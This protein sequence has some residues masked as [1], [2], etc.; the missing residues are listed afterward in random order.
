MTTT[1]SFITLHKATSVSHEHAL[2]IGILLYK[3][4]FRLFNS[5]I[6][7]KLIIAGIIICLQELF[8]RQRNLG[9]AG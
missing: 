6:I 9:L 4:A 5:L 1:A 7:Q 3:W 8:K 2:L